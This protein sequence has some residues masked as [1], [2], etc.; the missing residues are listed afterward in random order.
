[1]SMTN[2]LPWR[3]QRRVRCL[4]F[5]GVLFVATWLLILMVVFSLRMNPLVMSRALH[6]QLASMQSVQQVLVSRTRS[7]TETPTPV[8][9]PQRRDWQPVLESF[10]GMMP[11][12]VWLTE[13]RYQPPS[14]ILTGYA[15]TLP[16]LSA[17][18][19]GLGKMAGFTPGP[20][21]ELQQDDQ[22]RWRFTFHLR[23]E[24]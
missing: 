7:G 1:M 5:W 4:R 8:P 20:T 24:G 16:A 18:R 22:G 3:R 2:F 10:A 6:I 14:L 12:Q 19:D 11:S 23:S 21:G 13:L 15:A 17:L 9:A